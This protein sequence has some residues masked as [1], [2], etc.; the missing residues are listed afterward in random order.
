MHGWGLG[1]GVAFPRC[2]PRVPAR[3]A[4]AVEVLHDPDLDISRASP[5]CA[6]SSHRDVEPFAPL[7]PACRHGSR[8]LVTS[9]PVRAAAV[10]LLLMIVLTFAAVVY[11]PI[12][13]H[14]FDPLRLVPWIV[15]VAIG[16]AH[17]PKREAPRR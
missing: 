8:P 2:D 9:E 6:A 15:S 12:A 11:W 16:A 7:E 3:P 14:R 5:R 17:L 4:K 13:D 10:A 1:V